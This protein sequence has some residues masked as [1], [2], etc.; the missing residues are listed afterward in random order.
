[1][2]SLNTYKLQKLMDLKIDFSFQKVFGNELIIPFLNALLE[3]PPKDKIHRILQSPANKDEDLAPLSFLCMTNT[4]KK[5]HIFINVRN[6]FDIVKHSLY[7][8]AKAY[9]NQNYKD[10]CPVFFINLLN[11]ELLNQTESFH[12]TYLLKER[13]AEAPLLDVFELHFIEYPTLIKAFEAKKV[14]LWNDAKARWLLLLGIVDQRFGIFYEDLYK[15]MNLLSLRDEE[16]RLAFHKWHELSQQKKEWTAY[17]KRLQQTLDEE[18]ELHEA[19]QREKAAYEKGV[20]QLQINI[21]KKMLAD[22]MEIE[23][24]AKIT[25]LSLREIES[26]TKD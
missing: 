20:K 9:S 25:G 8:A 2:I 12:T 13:Q 19:K 4:G 10:I 15:E 7:Y 6:S 1:M 26:L 11:Y 5:L 21:A 24:V 3:R 18:K 17:E 16:I 23:Y 22:G 14:N